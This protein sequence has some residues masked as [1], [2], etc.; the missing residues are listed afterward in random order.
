VDTAIFDEFNIQCSE[1]VGDDVIAL[2]AAFRG[3]LAFS[4]CRNRVHTVG[5]LQMG[6]VKAQA[7][8]APVGD[9]GSGY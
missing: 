8:G 6:A 4:R 5:A 3:G 2:D 1:V 9:E 7:A